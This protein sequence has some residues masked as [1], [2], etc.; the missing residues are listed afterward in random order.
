[1]PKRARVVQEEASLRIASAS[2]MAAPSQGRWQRRAMLSGVAVALASGCALPDFNRLPDE[3]GGSNAVGH[4][5]GTSGRGTG[6]TSST[7]AGVPGGGRDTGATNGA[8]SLA[9]TATIEETAGAAGSTSIVEAGAGTAGVASTIGGAT[10]TG[11][12]ANAGAPNSGGTVSTSG[13][14]S[15]SGGTV[16]T[17][18]GAPNSGGTVSTSGGAPNSGGTVAIAGTSNAGGAAGAAGAATGGTAAGGLPTAGGAATGGV[19]ATGGAPATG[20]IAATGGI[21]STGRPFVPVS[22]ST[23]SCKDL[24]AICQGESC[25][26][27]IEMP[28]GSYPMG[29]SEVSGPASDYY[30]AAASYTQETPEHTAT[31]AAF[32]L[33]KY[34][35]TV[36]RFRKFVENY[37]AWHVRAN[38]ANPQGNAGAHP[39][40]ANTGWGQ[41]WTLVTTTPDLPANAAALMSALKCGTYDQTWTDTPGTTIAEAYPINCVSWY[42]AFAFCIWDSGRL[43]TE[44]EWEYAAAGGSQNRLY[45]WG[46]PAPGA[47][48]ANFDSSDN[49]PRVVVGS[50]LSTGGTGSFGHADLAGSM[51]EWAF[52]WY[53]ATYYRSGACNNCANATAGSSRVIRGSSWGSNVIGLRAAYRSNYAPASP[54]LHIGFRCARTP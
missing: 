40:A 47:A 11:G 24:G 8:A 45:P 17:S 14:A 1:M 16:S 22:A 48:L 4:H 35:I 43:P 20:G 31:V 36:G 10:S 2:L 54:D 25:C 39:I 51:Y 38:P 41:S 52:D 26:T 34:E 23:K 28:G 13:G 32:A 7:S 42:Q 3:P 29:R 27:S 9:G 49:S 53:N 46:N 50:K 15:N 5:A 12:T 30:S 18:G 33:D 21:P 37:N 6:G 44:A 19:S